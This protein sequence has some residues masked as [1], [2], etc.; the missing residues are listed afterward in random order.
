MSQPT[1][2]TADR[3]DVAKNG[4]AADRDDLSMKRAAR[5]EWSFKPTD[6]A[7]RVMV[8]GSIGADLTRD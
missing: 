1:G 8:G 4:R 5:A 7:R 6:E 2:R 3:D